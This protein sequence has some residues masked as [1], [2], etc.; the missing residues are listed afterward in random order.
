MFKTVRTRWW[1]FSLSLRTGK[2]LVWDEG[3]GMRE[4]SVIDVKG[5]KVRIC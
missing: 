1:C 4:G 2:L 5:S 3:I